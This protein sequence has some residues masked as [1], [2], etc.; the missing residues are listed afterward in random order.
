MQNRDVETEKV[1]YCMGWVCIGILLLIV[2]ISRIFPHTIEHLIM[3]CVFK[4]VT[5]YYC[6]GCGGTR[7]VKFFLTGHWIKSFIY[8]PLVIYMGLGG[9]IYMV[10]HT[11]SYI[12][13][14]RVKGMVFHLW[15]VYV[16]A[17]I[18]VVQFIIKNFILYKWGIY[19]I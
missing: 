3:P 19:I 10:T 7:A 2:V 1:L 5:G 12:T 15:Y 16:M 9:S 17:I 8:H 13:K 4:Q 18:I 14:G 11:L 6:P